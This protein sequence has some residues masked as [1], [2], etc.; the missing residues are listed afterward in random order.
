[1]YC[2]LLNK[3]LNCVFIRKIISNIEHFKLKN[4][5]VV[6]LFINKTSGF[7]KICEYEQ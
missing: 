3:C 4:S 1:M 7:I 2:I 6:H 5:E